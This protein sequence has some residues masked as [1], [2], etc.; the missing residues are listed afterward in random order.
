MSDK[1]SIGRFSPSG[2]LIADDFRDN[3]IIDRYDPIFADMRASKIKHLKSANSEDAVTWN[4]FRSLRQ[5]APQVWLPG[6]WE[7]A[8]PT[9]ACPTDLRAVVKL[10]QSVP[11][12]LGLLDGGDEGHSEIDVIIEAST[13][14]W[15]IE[16]K[17]RSDISLGTT[18]RP[19]R[20]QILRNLDVGSCYAGVREF[21]FSLLIASEGAS[22]K[23]VEK[24]SEYADVSVPRDRLVKHRPDGLKNLRAA[25]LLT[26][27]ALA[28]VLAEAAKAAHQDD[29]RIYAKRATEWL[30]E[31]GFGG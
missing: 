8:L 17:Y 29:E 24:M 4:V 3:L 5:I 28:D 6:L 15:F 19:Q 26:W 9:I 1:Q 21:F 18:T 31:R 22:P 12:P 25:G 7:R 23:G 11:P 14:V 16:A 10:W 27:A 2:V 30:R 13:W 20:D